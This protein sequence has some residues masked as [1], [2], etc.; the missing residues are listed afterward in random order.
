MGVFKIR[1]TL[2]RGPYNKDHSILF[3]FW[4]PLILGN[5]HVAIGAFSGDSIFW[6]LLKQEL[7]LLKPPDAKIGKAQ[8]TLDIR[9]EPCN[10]VILLMLKRP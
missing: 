2:F 4:G 1:G 10:D 6:T 5:Y 7:L 8:F 3:F 9:R